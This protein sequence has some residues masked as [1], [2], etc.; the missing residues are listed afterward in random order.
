LRLEDFAI[1]TGMISRM[2][3]MMEGRFS[4]PR[5]ALSKTNKPR[6]FASGGLRSSAS[7]GFENDTHVRATRRLSWRGTKG[8]RS[9]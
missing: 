8:F 6:T 2:P 4:W 9:R 1:R 7:F 3:T 5:V